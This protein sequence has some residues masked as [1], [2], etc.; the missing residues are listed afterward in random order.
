[1]T[2]ALLTLDVLSATRGGLPV[3][4]PKTFTPYIQNTSSADASRLH[5]VVVDLGDRP[6]SI[7]TFPDRIIRRLR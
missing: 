4:V 1:V 7:P 3:A 2:G 6:D 5:A